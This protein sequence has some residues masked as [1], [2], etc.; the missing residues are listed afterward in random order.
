[1]SDRVLNSKGEVAVVISPSFGS[2]WYSWNDVPDCLFSPV[3][4][5][6]VLK[7]SKKTESPDFQSL[8][9]EDFHDS[10]K[11][12]LVVVWVKEGE[13]FTLHEY[14]GSESLRLERNFPWIVA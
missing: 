11:H 1:M 3:V 5:D 8:F 10:A 12:D 9:G 6:W 4:V 13:K 14:D 7:G 2:G